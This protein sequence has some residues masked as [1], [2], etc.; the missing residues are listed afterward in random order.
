MNWEAIG[1]IGEIVGALAVFLTLI[2]LAI[3]IRQ[4]TKAVH[5]SAID[6][7]NSQISKICELV[8]ADKEVA[9]LY[10]RGNEDP[11]SLDEDDA[12]RYRLLIH[13]MLLALSNIITQA[14]VTGLSE[15]IWQVFSYR[16]LRG[17]F[18][19]PVVDG[20]GKHIGMSL[21]IHTGGR[22]MAYWFPG[23]NSLRM[24]KYYKTLQSLY[25]DGGGLTQALGAFRRHE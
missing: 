3:Q 21:K 1:A 6:S 7:A 10:R 15:S 25:T 12:V 11:A 9:N 4:N 8:F 17:W 23:T 20:F 5:A 18:P 19:L 16:L 14:S 22:L 13:S 2:Y 24:E